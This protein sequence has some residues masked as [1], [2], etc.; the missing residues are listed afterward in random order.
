V[1]DVSES[2]TE[3]AAPVEVAESRK[4]LPALV[5]QPHGG[6][7]YRGGVPGNKGGRPPSVLR[8]A[9]RRDLASLLPMLRRIASGRAP[10]K[11]DP[12]PSM[13]DRLKAVEVMARYGIGA[14]VELS[15][16][17]VQD[18]LHRT[19]DAIVR[20]LPAEQADPLIRELKAIWT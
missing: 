18:R 9:L 2:P 3:T 14:V 13:A 6:A 15:A 1:T 20:A 10:R 7:I 5:L 17:H 8:D 19:L 16:E 12:V 11:G 4:A